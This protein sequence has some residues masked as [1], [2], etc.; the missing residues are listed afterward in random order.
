M[1]IIEVVAQP[2]EYENNIDD[3]DVSA[4]PDEYENNLDDNE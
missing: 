4:P 1:V 3:A 2:D